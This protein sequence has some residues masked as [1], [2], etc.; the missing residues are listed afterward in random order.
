[1]AIVGIVVGL[2]ALLQGVAWLG[3]REGP[4]RALAGAALAAGGLLLALLAMLGQL[5]PDFYG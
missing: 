3:P 1:M 5:A 4:P 2:V